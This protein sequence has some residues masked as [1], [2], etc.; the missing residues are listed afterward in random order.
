MTG[1]AIALRDRGAASVMVLALVGMVLALTV[2]GLVLASVV[3]ASERARLAADLGSLA[4]ASAIQDGASA[5]G[6]CAAAQQVAR[7]N[8][9]ATQ[10]CSSV[11]SVVDLRVMVTAALWPEPAVA[12]ARAGP[13]R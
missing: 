4:G 8:G 10:S 2:S 11:D 7:A 5:A 12:H 13:E 1:R 6:A 3:V 9:A